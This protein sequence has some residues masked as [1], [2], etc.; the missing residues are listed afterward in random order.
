MDKIVSTPL[1]T[2]F[3]AAFN[4]G[5]YINQAIK[6][7]LS[8][9]FSDFELLIINDGSTDNTVEIINQFKDPRIRL[10]NNIKNNGLTFTRNYGIKEARG[11][12]FAI[13]DSDDVAEPRRLQ[14][15]VEFMK[16][17]PE[18]AICGGQARLIDE[19]GNDKGSMHVLAGQNEMSLQLAFCNVF[20]NSTLMMKR[21]AILDAD[22]YRDLAPA[23]DYD[24]SFR[25]SLKHK[26]ANLNDVLVS[27]RVHQNNISKTQATKQQLAEK[28]IIKSIHESLHVETNDELIKLHHDLMYGRIFSTPSGEFL[29]LFESLKKGNSNTKQYPETLFNEILFKKWFALLREKKEKNVIQLYFKNDLFEWQFHSFKQMRK[30][31]KQFLSMRL[32]SI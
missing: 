16:A 5:K 30:I 4:A 7:V 13:L 27:Y 1:V 19:N 28:S 23:E 14:I 25:I 2:V 24:L 3:M 8:Q 17:N 18:F 32:R 21:L 10:L 11:E 22:G 6:S 12:Y 20:I 15:Q 9:T 26:V 29:K 31:V